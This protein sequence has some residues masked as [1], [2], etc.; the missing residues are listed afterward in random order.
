V[1]G[2]VILLTG[3]LFLPPVPLTN[4]LP[5]F[6]VMLI[7]IAYLEE[8]GVLLSIGLGCA[9]LLLA[10]AWWRFGRSRIPPGSLTEHSDCD[11]A[12]A[13]SS[14]GSQIAS[15]AAAFY[16]SRRGTAGLARRDGVIPTLRS[17]GS[18]GAPAS[19][20]RGDLPS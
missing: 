7:S 4:L 2:G 19:R 3:G 6:V 15:E 1:I 18:C 9:L 5:A 10:G 8:D 20:R 11:P 13:G 14:I 16:F 12:R 17:V